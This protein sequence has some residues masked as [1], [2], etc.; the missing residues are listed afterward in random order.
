M[1][2]VIW[3]LNSEALHLCPPLVLVIRAKFKSF[4]LNPIYK[5]DFKKEKKLKIN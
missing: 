5:L 1:D 4:L 3:L 2:V